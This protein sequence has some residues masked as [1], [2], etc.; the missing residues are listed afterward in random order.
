M[1][2]NAKSPFLVF[3]AIFLVAVLALAVP[4]ISSGFKAGQIKEPAIYMIGHA[5]IDPVWRWTKDE[6][7][8]E[9]L[10]TFRQALNRMRE[11]PDVAF[12]S[13]SAQ[14]YKWVAE[15][16]PAMFAEIQR[17]V[18]EGRWNLVG[19]WWVEPD[20]NCPLGESLVRQGLYGQQFFERNF[21]RR[22]VVGF[23]PDTFGHP[24]TLPQILAGQGLKAYFFMRPSPSEKPELPAPLFIWKGPDETELLTAQILGSYNGTEDSIGEQIESSLRHFAASLPNQSAFA[25]FYGVGNH[26]GG[27]TVAAIEKIKELKKS[28]YPGIQFSTLDKYVAA[29]ETEQKSL[30]VVSDELQHHA[31][32]CYSAAA[33]VKSWNRKSEWALLTAEKI[34]ALDAAFCDFRYPAERFKSSWERVLFNQFHDILAGSA[35]EQAYIEAQ[36]DYSFA[37]SEAKEI[38]TKSLLDFALKINTMVGSGPECAPFLIFNPNSW[39]VKKPIEVEM[40][41]L[42]E[43]QP[44]LFAYNR[45]EIPFQEIRTAGVKVG[46]RIR[47]VFQD[48]FPSLGYK[49]YY[50]DFG[51]AQA[52]QAS[53]APKAAGSENYILENALVRITFDPASGAIRSYFDKTLG[54][55]LLSAPAAVPIVLEDTGDT[56]GHKIVSYDREVGRF[57][58]AKWTRIEN[59]P[60]RGRLQARSTFGKSYIVQDFMLY[61]DRPELCCRFLVDWQEYYKVLKLAF[62]SVLKNGTLTYS[63]PYGFIKRPMNGMEEPGQTWVDISGSD[64]RGNFGIALL[65]DSKCGYSVKDGE[66]RLTIFHSAAWSQHDPETLTESEGYRLMDTGTHEFSYALFPHQGDWRDAGVAREAEAFGMPPAVI[67]TDRH[68]GAW[69]GQREFLS[70]SASNVATTVLKMSENGSSLVLRLVELHGKPTRGTMT[71]PF[72]KSPINFELRP[73]E[74]KT[75]LLPLNKLRPPRVTNLLED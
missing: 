68:K 48:E 62:P 18:R 21:G 20:V 59:G 55:E 64:D 51:K 4:Q 30:P 31:R 34:A 61:K 69:E 47:F 14:F 13:S 43:G 8:A 60:E 45:R 6:G 50:L 7:R 5:H 11:N 23:N 70:T 3:S 57:G 9:V 27:P 36:N 66:I 63:I 72:Y 2:N 19:G 28:K 32:G 39:K 37:L 12:V 26:G 56:W 24:W 33:L 53:G 52:A 73:C 42:R 17:R 22:A 25:V 65:N 71:F 58:Q 54:R 35:I 15:S 44:S 16:D 1:L 41:R 29:I 74:I 46:S 40:E 67:L 75:F 38:T 10:A 49:L